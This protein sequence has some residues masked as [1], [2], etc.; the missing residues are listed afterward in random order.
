VNDGLRP[1][2]GAAW[3]FR[4]GVEREAARRFARLGAAIGGVDPGSPVIDL[5]GKAMTDEVRHA[6]LCAELAAA[7]GVSAGDD[8]PD[9]ELAP[10]GLGPREAILYEVVAACCITET[11]SVATVASLLAEPAEPQVRRVLHEIARDEIMHGRMGWTH[12]A[13]EA[14][15]GVGFLAG[16]IPDMLAGTVDP[17]LFYRNGDGEPLG[18]AE[19]LRHGVLQRARKREI[20]VG[21]LERVVFPGLERFGIDVGPAR[22]WLAGHMVTPR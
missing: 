7:Y 2:I 8:V 21:T 22:A 17:G 15:A 9:V 18:A 19:L 6:A 5:M 12:L 3:A 14:A 1:H 16:W 10:S 20:F 11:E 13:R 4:A